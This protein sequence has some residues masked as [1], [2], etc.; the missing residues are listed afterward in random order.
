MLLRS[1]CRFDTRKEKLMN[2]KMAD[3]FEL[4]L[5]VDQNCN[6]EFTLRAATAYMISCDHRHTELAY[7]LQKDQ[8]EAIVRAVNEY[9]EMREL[10]KRIWA[11]RCGDGLYNF[12]SMPLRE[13]EEATMDAWE[14]IESDLRK[15]LGD[16]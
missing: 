11:Y 7:F 8:A 2:K 12:A 3:R 9:D 5:E 6:V 1:I 13:R 16:K 15:L 10:L 4:P 14:E